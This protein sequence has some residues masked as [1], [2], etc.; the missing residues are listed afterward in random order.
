MENPTVLDVARVQKIFRYLKK[1]ETGFGISYEG[2]ACSPELVAYC[3]SDYAGDVQTRKSTTGYVIFFR[4]GHYQCCV[5]AT[6][7]LRGL[8]L[9]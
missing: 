6:Q 3:D 7:N 2:N 1:T 5:G 8:I 9:I 4:G